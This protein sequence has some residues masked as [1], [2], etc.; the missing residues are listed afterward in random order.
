MVCYKISW[1]NTEFF[2]R[3]DSVSLM[4]ETSIYL[5]VSR[6]YVMYSRNVSLFIEIGGEKLG[7]E[8]LTKSGRSRVRTTSPLDKL[9]KVN[10]DYK[11]S[12]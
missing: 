6:F 12:I 7:C 1:I 4:Y 10:L 8:P 5:E 11:F 3:M 9:N 2:L